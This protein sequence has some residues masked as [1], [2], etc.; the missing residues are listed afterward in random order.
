MSYTVSSSGDVKV[1][2]T[3]KVPAPIGLIVMVGPGGRGREIDAYN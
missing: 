3:G 2:K 1:S